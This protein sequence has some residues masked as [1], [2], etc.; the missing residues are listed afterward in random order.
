MLGRL[1][2]MPKNANVICEG[3]LSQ[4]AEMKLAIIYIKVNLRSFGKYCRF[5]FINANLLD[6]PLICAVIAWRTVL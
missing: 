5:K 6:F 1:G 2:Q 3:S 4:L